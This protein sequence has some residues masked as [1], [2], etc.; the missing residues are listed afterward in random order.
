MLEDAVIHHKLY[1]LDGDTF[2]SCRLPRT[3]AA[4][5]QRAEMRTRH[6]VPQIGSLAG[7]TTQSEASP[8][9]ALA[10]SLFRG[11][12]WSDVSL[13]L[14]SHLSLFPSTFSL[15]LKHHQH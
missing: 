9:C 4:Q 1:R 3:R 13:S 10:G 5:L 2:G 8:A 12:I 11:D 6:T 15:P 7:Q 14:S